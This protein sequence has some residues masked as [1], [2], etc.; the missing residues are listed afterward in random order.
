MQ[1][2]SPYDSRPCATVFGCRSVGWSGFTRLLQSDTSIRR[3]KLPVSSAGGLK[4]D[5]FVVTR[6]SCA[7]AAYQY[8]RN[9]SLRPCS[10]HARAPADSRCVDIGRECRLGF[11]FIRPRDGEMLV[12]LVR[13]VGGKAANYTIVHASAAHLAKIGCA[14]V[15]DFSSLTFAPCKS[16]RSKWHDQFRAEARPEL[17]PI[18]FPIPSSTAVNLSVLANQTDH[19]TAGTAR[20]LCNTFG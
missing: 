2:N 19:C 15:I 18:A 10:F 3:K 12:L 4:S 6:L 13:S 1:S 17:L 8:R 16:F 14:L 11:D 9:L 20:L 7:H 5:C